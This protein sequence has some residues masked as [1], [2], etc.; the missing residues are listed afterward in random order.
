MSAGDWKEMFAAC[1]N[2]NIE[3]V[4]Y[5]IET[6]VDPNY[7]HPE[8]LTTALMESV[9][10][11]RLEIIKYLLENGADPS[12]KDAWTSETAISIAEAMK[13]KEIIEMLKS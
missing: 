10:C 3:L 1:Q 9:R 6:G 12:I 2:G 8:F 11:K 4:R 7:T 5:H 13:E